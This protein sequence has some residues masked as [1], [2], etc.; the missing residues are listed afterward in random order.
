MHTFIVSFSGE[1]SLKSRGTRNRFLDR[2]MHNLADALKSHG[3]EY[4]LQRRWSRIL[5]ESESTEVP[6]VAS[7]V[8]GI[9]SIAWAR[10]KPW[11]T[12][13]D[14][15]RIGAEH[16]RPLVKG[17]TFAVRVKRGEEASRIPFKSPELERLL[18]AELAPHGAGVDLT[19]PEIEARVE[20]QG[21]E[22][23]YFDRLTPGEGG[24][25]VGAEGRALTLFSGGFDSP[26]A[27][28]SL[29]RRGVRQDF[30]FF[31]LAGEQHTREV[32]AVLKSLVD[33]WAFGYRPRCFI[34]D[35]L[36]VVEELKAESPARLWQVLLKR[37]MLA[38]ADRIA[39]FLQA[40]ALITGDA[41]GQVSSQTLQNLDVV[42]RVAQRPVLRPLVAWNKDEIIALARRIGTH[43]VS[44]RVPEYCGLRGP[45]G[46]SIHARLEDVEAAEARLDPGMLERVSAER[47]ILDLRA[48]DLG[49]AERKELEVESVPEGSRLID[50]RSAAAYEAWHPAGAVRC[51]YPEVLR[52]VGSF[53]PDAT[54][55]VYCEVGLKSA[56]LADFMTRAGLRTF[57]L[58][59]GVHTLRKAALEHDPALAALL[60]PAHRDRSS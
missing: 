32:L 56:H 41:V 24:L 3:V 58:K 38:A 33:G 49:A 53:E 40:S 20:L 6:K 12:L 23:F 36:P 7:R 18:G 27:A 50:L 25:P 55:V 10:K 5:I 37:R 46:P 42:S 26:V 19:R 13:D 31:N 57:H 59:R 11:K 21:E 52:H 2:L 1:M 45:S 29:W 15:V 39:E 8:F 30:V 51:P 14:L 35:F 4:R 28:W 47:A 60:S 54:Y 22:A 9:Q 44:A 17:R 16:F 43:D 34:I 48:F